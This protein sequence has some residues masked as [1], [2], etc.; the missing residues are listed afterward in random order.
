[1]LIYFVHVELYV[2]LL[3]IFRTCLTSHTNFTYVNALRE[4]TQ[5]DGQTHIVD[6]SNL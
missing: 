2:N 4:D 3:K 1:M 5:T 6:K